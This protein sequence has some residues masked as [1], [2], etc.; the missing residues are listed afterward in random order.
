MVLSVGEIIYGGHVFSKTIVEMEKL[1][2]QRQS[3]IKEKIIE[4]QE[5]AK[6]K[7]HTLTS[8]EK[9]CEFTMCPYKDGLGPIVG[10]NVCSFP[11]ETKYHAYCYGQWLINNI[12]DCPTHGNNTPLCNKTG[13]DLESARAL[14]GMKAGKRR[15]KHS[16]RSK[17]S[18]KRSKRSKRTRRHRK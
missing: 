13:E 3:Q 18:S 5:K 4:A 9:G 10:D 1:S 16:K 17:R 11:C 15:N 6:K 7:G 12:T 14:A 2:S 8:I